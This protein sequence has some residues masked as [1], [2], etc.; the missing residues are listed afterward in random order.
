MRGI[1]MK[2]S[3][4]NTQHSY[5]IKIRIYYLIVIILCVAVVEEF[6]KTNVLRKIISHAVETQKQVG[7]YI[8]EKFKRIIYIII[9][10]TFQAAFVF[11]NTSLDVKPSALIQLESS[12]VYLSKRSIRQ[13][14]TFSSYIYF[15]EFTCELIKIF[16]L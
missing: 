7:T 5:Q 13:M 10:C 16:Q 12:D 6:R 1:H 14:D 9:S 15:L 8:S 2:N 11:S 4:S 3:S